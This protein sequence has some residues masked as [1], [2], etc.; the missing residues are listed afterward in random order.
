[1]LPV[2][3][4]FEEM[5]TALVDTTFVVVDLETT[6]GSPI[7]SQITEIGAVKVRGGDLIGEFSTLVDPGG[8]IPPFITVLTGITNAMVIG[9]PRIE[10]ALPTFLEFAGPDVVLVAH[11]AAFDSRFLSHESARLGYRDWTPPVVCTVR[12]ARRLVRDE[13]PNLRLATLANALNART[14]CHRALADA[15]AATDVLHALLELAGRWGVTHLDDLLWFQSAGGHPQARKRILADALPRGRG[16]YMFYGPAG[17]LLY[18]GKAADLR[19]RV[20]SYFSGDD[21]R[22]IGALL[23]DL[24]EV[25]HL[26]TRLDVESAVLE[27]RLI[28][29]HRP[30]YNRAGRGVAGKAWIRLTAERFPRVTI[31]RSPSPGALGP[32]TS[33]RAA[34]VREALEESAP[35]RRCND[36]IGA[37][38]RFA[39]CLLEEIG[40]CPAPCDGRISPEEYGAGIEP[41]NEALAGDPSAALAVLDERMARLAADTRYE[42]AANTRDRASVLATVIERNR[43]AGALASAGRLVVDAGGT[44]VVIEDGR[45]VSVTGRPLPVPADGHADEARILERWL[46]KDPSARLVECDGDYAMP[47]AGGRSIA[48][49]LRRLE[50]ARRAEARAG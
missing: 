2:Q 5:G 32:L 8:P 34:A 3:R 6:G 11:N 31:A 36:R 21:R 19:S 35:I 40:R 27:A 46:R 17:E 37:R 42:E 10:E 50:R 30:P 13:V 47:A 29:R 16:V 45:L 1:M 28:R 4:S 24:R 33:S 49:W 38:T 41:V 9:A 7:D 48:S 43:T 22:K 44:E 12:L 20:R 26:Q 15:R 39:P 18:V 25:G 23:R 14:P